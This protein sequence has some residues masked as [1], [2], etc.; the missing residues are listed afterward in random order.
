M[1]LL[2]YRKIRDDTNT[3]RTLQYL[4]ALPDSLLRAGLCKGAKD[5]RSRRPCCL[6]P[7][8]LRLVA[9]ASLLPYFCIFSL[10]SSISFDAFFPILAPA[11]KA[12]IN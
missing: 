1:G 8:F 9:S 12:A 10:K 11:L 3:L 4:V 7:V 5:R 2:L 6:L